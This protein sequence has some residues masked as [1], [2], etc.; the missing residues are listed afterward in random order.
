MADPQRR[1]E[2]WAASL[3]GRLLCELAEEHGVLGLAARVLLDAGQVE[4]SQQA[5]ETLRSWR[6]SHAFF[7]LHLTA[8]MLRLFDAF[9]RLRI[10]ALVTKGPALSVRCYGDAGVRQY[11]DLDLVVREKDILRVTEL[12]LGLGYEGTVPLS[13]IRAGKI[14][15][16][17]NFQ[18]KGSPVLVEFHTE[19]TFRY[20]PR[21]LPIENLFRR[22]ARVILD[23][24]EVPVLSPEDELILVCIHGAKHFWERLGYIADVAGLVVRQKLDWAQVQSAAAEVNAERMLHVAVRLAHETLE[25]SPPEEV[26]RRVEAEAAARKLTAQILRRLP[27]AGAAAPGIFGRAMFR[28]RMRGGGLAG[29]RYLLRLSFSPTEEDWGLGTMDHRPRM[30]DV[31]G[32]PIRLARKYGSGKS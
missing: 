5:A 1:K 29:L 16:E 24:H 13:A 25:A 23:G 2:R 19:R 3:N 11:G 8:E 10:E 30:L 12:M 21:P 6:R 15:G 14:P 31:L 26:L 22:Q 27:A 17:Y 9:Q 32:R 28:A 20:H 7:V 4:L 18:R